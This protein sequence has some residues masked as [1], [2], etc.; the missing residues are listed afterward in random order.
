VNED[1][2]KRSHGWKRRLEAVSQAPDVLLSMIDD[3][4][5]IITVGSYILADS[6]FSTP[7]FIR[8]IAKRGLHFIGRLKDNTTYFLFR[9]NGKDRLFTLGQLY[10]KL[11]RIPKSVRKKQ[12]QTQ[13]IL[14]SFRVALPSVKED[15]N[16]LPP[17]FVRIVF[18]KNRNTSAA[19]EWIAI[20]TTDLELTE[21]EVVRMYAKRWKIE[22]FFKVAKSLLKLEREFQ[23]RSYDMLFAH[24]TIVCV[25]YIF[26]EL[27]RR[28]AADIRTCGELFYHCCDEIPDLK[29]A[30][31]IQ[32]IFQLLTKFF[33]SFLPD[34]EMYIRNFIASLPAPILR[35]LLISGCES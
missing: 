21:E 8:Q 29:T 28:R 14:G 19:K 31:A 3:F 34:A 26:L 9:R 10:K 33:A 1:I 23:G 12:R 25:R 2:D 7:S 27:E 11:D 17:V 32:L 15:G 16:I 35:F 18:L 4:R 24:A 13:D 20:L 22:E 6:W 5:D 30:E